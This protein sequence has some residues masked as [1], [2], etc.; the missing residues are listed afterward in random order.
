MRE[1]Y[2]FELERE[3][4]EWLVALSDTDYK[5]VDEVAALLAEKGTRLG[6][7]WSDHLEGSVWELRVRLRDV[8]ARVT[9]WCTSNGTIV[10]LTVFHKTKQHD[11][12]QIDRAVRMQKICER[13]HHGPV[14]ESFERQV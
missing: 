12:R 7:P 14:T 13:D 6:G 1:L 11:Q 4:R 8:A 2:G 9:Y 10:F 5:R 3:V